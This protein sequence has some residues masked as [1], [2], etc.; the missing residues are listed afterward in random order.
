MCD[1]LIAAIIEK[2]DVHISPI[3]VYELYYGGYYSGK[4]K[5]V[6]DV[7][8]MMNLGLRP[9]PHPD[10]ERGHIIGDRDRLCSKLDYITACKAAIN[11]NKGTTTAEA[12]IG[13]L[14]EERDG[15]KK[16]Y[17]R[18]QSWFKEQEKGLRED[19]ALAAIIDRLDPKKSAEKSDDYVSVP[20]P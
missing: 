14:I 4:L 11:Q 8:A 13:R 17:K 1:L 5:P 15:E 7:L 18:N 10:G 20:K 2:Y 9:L 6:E 16:G 19:T 12:I 3:S